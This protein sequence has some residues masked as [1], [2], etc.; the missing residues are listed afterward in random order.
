MKVIADQNIPFIKEAFK[1]FGEI[2]LASGREINNGML[3]EAD[4]LLV[5][6]VTKVNE[7][8]LKNCKIKFVAT[9]TIG[10]DH[11]DT[12]YLKEKNIGFASA[13]GSNADSV[14]EY[15]T[16]SLLNLSKKNN[17]DL[18][19]IKLGIIGVGN[20]GSRVNKRAKALGITTLLNDPPKRRETND[21]VYLALDEVLADADIVTVHVPLNKTGGDSTYKLINKNFIQKMKKGS[22][23]FNTSRGNVME[24]SEVRNAKGYLSDI[25]LDVWENEPNINLDTLKIAYISTP[26]IAGYSYDGKV[27]GTEMIYHSACDYFKIKKNWDKT[28]FVKPE[29]ELLID[30]TNS[31]NL[32]FDAIN[33]AYPVH[34]DSRELKKIVDVAPEGQGKYFDDL[35]KNYPK[36]RE[37]FNYSLSV[38]KNA[39]KEIVK[40]LMLLGFKVNEK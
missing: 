40:K 4:I 7:E 1:E 17:F 21:S 26:H 22:I 33:N 35:R 25:I 10:I 5:R 38:N 19:K 14:A 2:T 15:I 37:F 11:I 13:P 18:T 12:N 27:N 36:R 32:L 3:L 31:T 20:V 34:N 23:L 30:L 6:S 39:D 24:E 28:G 29:K 9:A 16:S 8:L